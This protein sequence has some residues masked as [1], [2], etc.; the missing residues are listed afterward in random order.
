MF[1]NYYP[2]TNAMMKSVLLDFDFN[3]ISYLWQK[4]KYLC[5]YW[6]AHR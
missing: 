3:I 5:T 1:W 4:Y 2:D 6:I